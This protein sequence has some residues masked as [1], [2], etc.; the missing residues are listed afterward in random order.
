MFWLTN[1]NQQHTTY[2]AHFLFHYI[3]HTCIHY[4]QRSAHMQLTF[5]LLQVAM[6]FWSEQ[7]KQGWSSGLVVN[8]YG[9]HNSQV[10]SYYG[11]P[12]LTRG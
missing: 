10:T 5:L 6:L 2:Y 12:M 9:G 8:A 11:H 3:I 7:M 4:A 1:H